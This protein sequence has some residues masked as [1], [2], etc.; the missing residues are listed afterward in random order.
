[1]GAGLLLQYAVVILAVLLSVAFV[2]KRQFPGAVRRLRVA[3]A[4]PLLRGNRAPWLQR[5]GRRI[6]PAPRLAGGCGGCNGCEP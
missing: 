1:M 6:A 2:A 3:C 4:I 5:V